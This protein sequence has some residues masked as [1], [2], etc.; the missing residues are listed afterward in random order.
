MLVMTAIAFLVRLRQ[1]SNSL[2][3]IKE[4]ILAANKQQP[5]F[6]LRVPP[7]LT[8]SLN[9]IARAAS[10]IEAH[11]KAEVADERRKQRIEAEKSFWGEYAGAEASRTCAQRL[12]VLRDFIEGRC[13]GRIDEAVTPSEVRFSVPIAGDMFP[14]IANCPHVFGTGE[15]I[16]FRPARNPTNRPMRPVLGQ[17]FEIN[18]LDISEHDLNKL[19]AGR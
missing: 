9:R 4:A 7:E 15:Q 6:L 14:I 18:L 12:E 19:V 5:D 10:G 13:G 17:C 11:L 8:D 16:Q 3:D 1:L 2:L